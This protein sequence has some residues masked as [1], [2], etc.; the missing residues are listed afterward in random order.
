MSLYLVG[1]GPISDMAL[2]KFGNYL[3]LFV[4]RGKHVIYIQVEAESKGDKLQISCIICNVLSQLPLV[5]V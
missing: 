4:Y 2:S 3:F 5:L 1:Q